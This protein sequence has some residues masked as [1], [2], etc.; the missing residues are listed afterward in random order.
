MTDLE[1]MRNHASELT[2]IVERLAVETSEN[3]AN[4]QYEADKLDIALHQLSE[5]I[6]AGE[7]KDQIRRKLADA[8]RALRALRYQL[9]AAGAPC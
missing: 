1:D 3:N 8:H 9:N 5:A 4:L 2:A 7:P 6:D